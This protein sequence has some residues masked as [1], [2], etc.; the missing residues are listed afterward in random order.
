ML[1]R[2][3]LSYFVCSQIWL[4]FRMDDRH[5]S[6]M[7]KMPKKKKNPDARRRRRQKRVAREGGKRVKTTMDW[8]RNSVAVKQSGS[9]FSGLSQTMLRLTVVGVYKDRRGHSSLA[10]IEY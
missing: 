5:F 10:N 1:K 9:G 7:R 2:F 6:H 4:N 8:Q 3:L